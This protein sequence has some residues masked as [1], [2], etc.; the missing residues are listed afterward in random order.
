[1]LQYIVLLGAAGQLIGISVYIKETIRGNTKP[2]RV[3][4]LMWSIATLIAAAAE[5]TK[6]VG[7][8]VLPIFIAGFAPFLVFI[9]TF[10]NKKSYWKLQTFDYICGALSLLAIFFWWLTKEANVAIVFAIAADAFAAIPTYKKAITHP[11]SESVAPFALGF[12]NALTSFFAL[13]A[14]NFAELAFPIYLVLLDA[15]FTIIIYR[16]K[17]KKV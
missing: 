10:F 1:M 3:S 14:F 17:R 13:V 11:H 6:G 12:F 4:W 5:V 7:W 15:S 9:A 16:G 2:N 8:A